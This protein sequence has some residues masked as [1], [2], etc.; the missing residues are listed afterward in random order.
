[1]AV[2]EKIERHIDAALFAGGDQIIHSVLEFRF[3][4]RGSAAGTIAGVPVEVMQTDK[5]VP[6]CGKL[7]GKTVGKRMIHVI[8][9]EA[10]I[11]SVKSGGSA[12]AFFKYDIAVPVLGESV[13]S[14][15][16]IQQKGEIK[17]AVFAYPA[18]SFHGNPFG[19]RPHDE[20]FIAFRV[21]LIFRKRGGDNQPDGLP[22][23][24]KRDMLQSL[25]VQLEP[26][27]IKPDCRNVAL[28]APPNR[29]AG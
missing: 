14:G 20:F 24:F 15:G 9:G 1:M 18:F 22:G 28:S 8:R 25:S 13:F 10:D 4:P 5:V 2:D 21:D 7:V 27:H 19:I 11:R 17:N 3:H 6:D 23:T 16:G 12:G 26:G 29:R